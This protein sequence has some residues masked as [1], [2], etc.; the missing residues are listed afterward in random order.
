M[1]QCL[2]GGGEVHV[3][4]PFGLGE[5]VLATAVVEDGFAAQLFEDAPFAAEEIGDVVDVEADFEGVALAVYVEVELLVDAEADAIDPRRSG[6]IAHAVFATMRA[7]VAIILNEGF[8]GVAVVVA[9]KGHGG[10]FIGGGDID[11]L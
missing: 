9:D 7:E 8:V 4:V 3:G 5:G 1:E 10:Q 6:G 11:E 2:P